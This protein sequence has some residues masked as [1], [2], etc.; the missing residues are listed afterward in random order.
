MRHIIHIIFLVML[1][2]LVT[3]CDGMYRYDGRLVAADSIMW[4]A[5]DSALAIVSTIDTLTGEANQAYCDL[6]MTQARYK[7]YQ[8]ITA[9]DDS[10][11][12][13]AITYYRTHSGEREKLTRAYLYKGAVMEE[14]GRVDSAM[15]YYKTAEVNADEK[16]Y[17]TLGYVNMR[18]GALYRDH[19]SIDGKDIEKYELAHKYLKLTDNKYYQVRCKINLGSLYRL[20]K[21]KD[22]EIL[23]HDAMLLAHEVN[24][25]TAYITCLQNL[26]MLYDH[27]DEYEKAREQINHIKSFTIG[28]ISNLCLT[29]SARVYAKLGLIDTAEQYINLAKSRSILNPIEQISFYEGLSAIALAK[30]DT[31][32][33]LRYERKSKYLSDSI[34]SIQ[35][36]VT[37]L[38]AEHE[39]DQTLKIAQKYQYQKTFT[40]LVCLSIFLILALLIIHY[41]R[42]H[43]YDKI[44]DSIKQQ[45]ASQLSDLMLLK[46]RIENLKIQ[47][48]Q[49]KSFISSHLNL[50]SE[51]IEACY[52]SPKSNLSEQ[53]KRIVQFQQDNKQQWTQ[54]YHYIDVEYNGII[55]KTHKAYPQLNDK[56]L[57]LIALTTTGF[58]YVQIAIIMGY[59]NA[60]SVGTIKQRLAHKMHLDGSLNDY[61]NS[62]VES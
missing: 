10:A 19:Y 35:Q 5:P 42:V 57:L 16:D 30:N 29:S 6:L 45:S 60:T 3:G 58:S 2:T 22:A 54:L 33:Y 7:C 13:H 47:D 11:I 53:V 38:N 24:D 8:E 41:R 50:T 32:M 40:W 4:D 26:I 20:N 23:L 37:I 62:M 9:S 14:L 31:L 61:I 55:S 34:K 56:D 28:R 15:F 18:M 44:I 36:T 39:F 25:T 52:H 59:A 21:P 27:N 48:Q 17:F 49:L 46:Q 12:S 51:M 43:R 1:V